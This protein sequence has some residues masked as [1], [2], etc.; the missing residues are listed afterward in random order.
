MPQAVLRLNHISCRPVQP[1]HINN[2]QWDFCDPSFNVC[3][4]YG[5]NGARLRV[6]QNNIFSPPMS[7]SL[8]LRK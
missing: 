8:T 7:I 1:V 6:P 5:K 4:E 3:P 2:L